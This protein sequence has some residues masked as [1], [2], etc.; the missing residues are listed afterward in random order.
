M[1]SIASP[2]SISSPDL[3][4]EASPIL[5][6]LRLRYSFRFTDLRVAGETH[7]GD[8]EFM[9]SACCACCK[10]FT[11]YDLKKWGGFSRY[12]TSNC[13]VVATMFEYQGYA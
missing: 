3:A 4:S 1:Y 5:L 8:G 2:T 13:D 9:L 7:V 11:G 12:I 10:H 6:L